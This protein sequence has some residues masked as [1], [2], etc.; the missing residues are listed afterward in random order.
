MRTALVALALL[1]AVPIVASS[2]EGGPTEVVVASVKHATV[3]IQVRGSDWIGSGS[4]FVVKVE[5]DAVYVATNFHV[6]AGASDNRRLRPTEA[7]RLVSASKINLV[8][9]S[10]AKSERTAKGEAVA[11]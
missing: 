8:F 1:G 10:G 3:F 2:Q 6:L 9:D 7:N 11:F 4:G 5:K